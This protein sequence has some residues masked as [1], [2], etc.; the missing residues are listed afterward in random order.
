MSM[1]LYE[2]VKTTE[3]FRARQ[4]K[5]GKVLDVKV[6][7]L[8][9]NKQLYIQA[10][11]KSGTERNKTYKVQIVFNGIQ[12]SPKRTRLHTLKYIDI[13]GSVIW[14][15]RADPRKHNILTRCTCFTGDTLIP[16]ADGYSVPIRDLVGRKEFH[17][18][19][20]DNLEKRVKIGKGYN[21]ESKGIEKVYKV[22][23]DN[24]NS[25][26]CTGDHKFL[27]K[28]GEYKELLDIIPGE[29]LMPLYRV[30]AGYEMVLN[31]ITGRSDYTYHLSAEYNLK[32]SPD[33]CWMEYDENSHKTRRVKFK[34]DQISYVRH[35][36]D[37]NKQNNSPSNIAFMNPREHWKLHRNDPYFH[38]RTSKRMK[39]SNPMKDR[40]VVRKMVKTSRERGYYENCGEHFLDENGNHCVHKM[41]EEGR[42]EISERNMKLYSEGKH[43]FQR[44]NPQNWIDSFYKDKQRL[45]NTLNW[46]NSLPFGVSILKYSDFMNENWNKDKGTTSNPFATCRELSKRLKLDNSFERYKNEETGKW[47]YKIDKSSDIVINHKI[48]SIEEIGEEE[49]F[50]FTVEDYHNFAIVHNCDDTRYV[51]HWYIADKQALL[52]PRIPY[53]RVPGSTRPSVN[54]DKIEVLCKHQLELIRRL[55]SGRVRLLKRDAYIVNYLSR[56]KREK[57]K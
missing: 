43:S 48:V 52:G 45:E 7:Y 6:K 16:L 42:K 3:T 12:S 17:V 49:V 19:S 57:V 13:D 47:N 1:T 40:E 22:T 27:M 30:L 14:I 18:Y 25:I 55:M 32:H 10:N 54:P 8:H 29:S 44:V 21:C 53:Q 56:P 46:F 33:T 41:I 31:P 37:F 51:G 36:V 4:Y 26:K 23:F 5:S 20:F 9:W 11:V 28:S 50:C 35:H 2:L 24:G 15:E 39:L 34:E 38:E